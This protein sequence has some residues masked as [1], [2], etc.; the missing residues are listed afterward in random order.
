MNILDILKNFS[1][2]S[3]NIVESRA[4]IQPITNK[5]TMDLTNLG[6]NSSKTEKV[7]GKLVKQVNIQTQYL[8]V[9]LDGPSR[10]SRSPTAE[11]SSLLAPICRR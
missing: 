11:S 1:K 2:Y 4:S 8:E 5:N 7:L 6:R 3:S 10:Q 9:E